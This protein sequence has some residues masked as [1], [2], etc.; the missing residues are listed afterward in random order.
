MERKKEK[1]L[2]GKNVNVVSSSNEEKRRIRKLEERLEEAEEEIQ[3]IKETL[4][5]G[6][7]VQQEEEPKKEDE[8]KENEE[9]KQQEEENIPQ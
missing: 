3:R 7:V 9:P 2:V 1:L 8:K 4:G 6:E 5:M